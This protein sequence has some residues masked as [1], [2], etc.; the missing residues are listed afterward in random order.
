MLKRI[1]DIIGPDLLFAL[2][3]MGHGDDIAIVDANFPAHSHAKRL[4]RAD[5]SRSDQLLSAILQLMPIDDFAHSAVRVMATADGEVPAI[6]QDFARI[7]QLSED[8]TVN[9]SPLTREDFYQ[10]A[11]QAFCIVATSEPRLYGN[12]LV[13]KGVVHPQ[14]STL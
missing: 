1:P 6:T 3:Q 12:C 13:R 8:R 9:P 2:A 5:A 10:Q 7:C 4:I 11:K 14:D